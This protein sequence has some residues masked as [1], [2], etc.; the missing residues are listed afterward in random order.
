MYATGSKASQDIEW[1]MKNS[2]AG[3]KQLKYL[4]SNAKNTSGIDSQLARE[5]AGYNRD[6]VEYMK[7]RQA[8][9]EQYL[10]EEQNARLAE[11]LYSKTLAGGVVKNAINKALN[12]VKKW[13]NKTISDISSWGAGAIAKGKSLLKKLFG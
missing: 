13:G 10:K 8:D 2:E 6:V 3:Q 7:Q 5:R 4:R 1:H 12:D 9:Y 11:K